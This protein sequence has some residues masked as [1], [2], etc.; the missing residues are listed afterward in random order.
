[1]TARARRSPPT[2]QKC[3]LCQ[4]PFLV[5]Q[6]A[7]RKAKKRGHRVRFCSRECSLAVR[8][9]AGNAN[10]RGG[11]YVTAAGYVYVYRPDHPAATK[12]GYVMEHRLVAEKHLGRLLLETEQV[13]HKN[14]VR[15]DNRWKNLKVMINIAAHRK[16]HADYRE[17]KCGWCKAPVMRSAA[18][19]R[20]YKHKFCNRTCAAAYASKKARRR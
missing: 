6:S 1:M 14:H 11:K 4:T 3:E 18:H 20:R 17:A 19:R 13:H 2:E 9:G 15:N 7:L 8:S 16:E 12:M 10:W 5:H